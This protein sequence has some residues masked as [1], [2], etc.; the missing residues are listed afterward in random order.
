[1]RLDTQPDSGS[2]WC[3][4]ARP[5]STSMF[6][7]VGWNGRSASRAP[8]RWPSSRFPS[9]NSVPPKRCGC[10]V[11]P[12]QLVTS[13]S[14]LAPISSTH[15]FLPAP[16]RRAPEAARPVPRQRPPPHGG[17]D[18]PRGL[19]RER[20]DPVPPRVTVP[21]QGGRRVRADRAGRVGAGGAR[22]PPLHHLGDGALGRRDQRP[23]PADV[24]RRRGD[25]ALPPG[26][27]HGVLLPERRGGRGRVRA[28]G[29][30]DPRDDVRRRA[31]PCGRLRGDPPRDDVPLRAGRAA[32][33]SR[34]R[35]AR[36]D[37]DP[38]PLPE[39]PRPADG[40]RAV[41]PP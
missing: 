26:G 1:M 39:R 31:L 34:L 27:A 32:A 14:I 18:G 29:A 16:R 25:L 17:G 23:A 11:T 37:H 40:A 5:V 22:A 41:L 30:G 24:E 33:A 8:C 36:P 10:A 12:S 9:L 19:L 35:D 4:S 20:V 28:R 38:A 2:T 13:R 3:G 15:A 6:R 7:S 21:D